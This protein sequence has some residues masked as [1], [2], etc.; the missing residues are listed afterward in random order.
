MVVLDRDGIG[1][2][3][4]DITRR[5]F[6]KRSLLMGG[7]LIFFPGC[8]PG[9]EEKKGKPWHPAYAKLEREGKFAERIERVVCNGM[10]VPPRQAGDHRYVAHLEFQGASAI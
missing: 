10:E 7:S 9:E 1:M 4:M 2:S 3:A 8:L 5:D 6:I